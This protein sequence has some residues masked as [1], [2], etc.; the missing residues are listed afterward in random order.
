MRLEVKYRLFNRVGE[1]YVPEAHDSYS[2][3]Y[4]EEVEKCITGLK[5]NYPGR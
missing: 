4:V 3:I 1:R 5:R 2:V